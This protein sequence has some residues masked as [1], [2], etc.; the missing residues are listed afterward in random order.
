MMRGTTC[1]FLIE[2]LLG[3]QPLRRFIKSDVSETDSV[4]VIRVVYK[5]GKWHA[6][7]CH[8]PDDGDS[9]C[10]QTIGFYEFPVAGVCL[11]KLY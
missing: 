4:S 7:L 10:L 6:E 2:A 3:R 5:Q 1:T 8:Y 11:R 9:V